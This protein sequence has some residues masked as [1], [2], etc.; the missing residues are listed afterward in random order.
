VHRVS[1]DKNCYLLIC[2]SNIQLLL[3]L[4]RAVIKRCA[5]THAVLTTAHTSSHSSSLR[6]ETIAISLRMANILLYELLYL[7]YFIE[8][9]HST[10]LIL[11]YYTIVVYNSLDILLSGFKTSIILGRREY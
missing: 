4:Q 9:R 5:R 2:Y 6:I 7:Y 1:E 11:L 8:H 10:V 3:L